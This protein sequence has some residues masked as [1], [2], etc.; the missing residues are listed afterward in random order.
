MYRSA[1][2]GATLYERTAGL[3]HA[4]HHR[5][6]EPPRERVL[7]ARVERRDEHWRVRAEAV[8]R[9]VPEHRLWR[10]GLEPPARGVQAQA[11]VERDPTQREHDAEIRHQL[12]RLPQEIRAVGQLGR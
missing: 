10:A 6:G 5:G 9:P 11:S 7:L 8:N 4:A 2:P 1:G 12:H 3:E